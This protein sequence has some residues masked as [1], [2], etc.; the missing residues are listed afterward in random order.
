MRESRLRVSDFV[1]VDYLR[2]IH[3]GGRFLV[4]GAV[5]D[6]SRNMKLLAKQLGIPVYGVGA[7]QS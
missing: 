2:L 4:G 5:A 6:I 1:V 3:A 7:T